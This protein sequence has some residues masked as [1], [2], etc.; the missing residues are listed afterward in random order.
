MCIRDSPFSSEDT[1]NDFLV[2]EIIDS[3]KHGN[4]NILLDTGFVYTPFT[5]FF[6]LDSFKYLAYDGE[7]YSEPAMVTIEVSEVNDKPIAIDDHFMVVED[8]TLHGE[9]HAEDGD[10]FPTQQEMQDLTYSIT[11]STSNGT[12]S[13]V[14][15]T[16]LTLPTICSV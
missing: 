15:Y 14:S 16:H 2:Y 13:A 1:D 12:L 11:L 9:L 6:G 3:S 7:A 4:I 10:Y 8:D 5:N